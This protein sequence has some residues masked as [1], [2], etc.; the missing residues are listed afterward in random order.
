MRKPC[1]G[2]RSPAERR[3]AATTAAA[4]PH[5]PNVM[6]GCDPPPRWGPQ[7]FTARVSSFHSFTWGPV[8]R[9]VPLLPSGT[10]PSG[11]TLH[12]VRKGRRER[13]RRG[14]HTPDIEALG[15]VLTAVGLFLVGVLVPAI[16]SGELGRAVRGALAGNVGWAAYCL[17]VP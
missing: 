16:P 7:P 5:S 8:G 15:L 10:S 11:G 2:L 14:E 17:T 1:H 12:A 6:T 4:R 3:S 13:Q 9:S